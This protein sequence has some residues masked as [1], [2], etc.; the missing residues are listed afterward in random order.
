MEDENKLS[1]ILFFLVGGGGPCLYQMFVCVVG[2]NIQNSIV[3]FGLRTSM[4]N[5]ILG[6]GVLLP[7]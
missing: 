4:H 5:F 3:Y 7:I 6:V 2:G 1:F